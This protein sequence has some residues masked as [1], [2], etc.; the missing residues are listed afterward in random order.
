MTVGLSVLVPPFEAVRLCCSREAVE[1]AAA[2][3]AADVARS[4]AIYRSSSAEPS[5]FFAEHL[6]L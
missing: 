6:V 4:I 5:F 1:G 2:E 3:L